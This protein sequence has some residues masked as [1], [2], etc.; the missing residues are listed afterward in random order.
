[1]LTFPTFS[2]SDVW[3]LGD[4]LKFALYHLVFAKMSKRFGETARRWSRGEVSARREQRPESAPPFLKT[5]SVCVPYLL[6]VLVR[7]HFK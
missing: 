4:I 7:L 6:G 5:A 2:F 3:E 1:M